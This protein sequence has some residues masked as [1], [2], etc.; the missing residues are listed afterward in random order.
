MESATQ[1]RVERLV[2]VMLR[3]ARNASQLA[4]VPLVRELC[5][6]LDVSSSVAMLRTLVAMSFSD[7][8]SEQ[9]LYRLILECDLDGTVSQEGAARELNVSRRHFYRLRSEAVAMIATQVERTLGH[10]VSGEASHPFEI[11]A[12]SMM[13]TK[14]GTAGD[15][16]S[17]LGDASAVG[18]RLL[19]LRARV[20]AGE[21]LTRDVAMTLPESGRPAA[22]ALVA[23]SQQVNGASYGAVQSLLRELHQLWDR[24]ERAFDETT[25]FELEY[26]NFLQQRAR[27][28]VYEMRSSA[29]NLDR[30]AGSRAAWQARALVANAEAACRAGESGE[31]R[32]LIATL[33]SQAT[34][35]RDVRRLGMANLFDATELLLEQQYRRAE[36]S[37][38]AAALA[39]EDYRPE[40]VLSQGALGRICLMTGATWEPAALLEETAGSSFDHITFRTIYARTLVARGELG[41]AQEYA[42]ESL[43]RATADEFTARAPFARV[44]L[45]ATF[46]RLGDVQ[47][48]QELYAEAIAEF[49]SVYDHVTAF[50]LFLVP[51][52]PQRAFGPFETIEP[53]VDVVLQRLEV[54]VPNLH[55][56]VDRAYCRRFVHSVLDAYSSGNSKLNREEFPSCP[57]H[58]GASIAHRIRA[59][60]EA[61]YLGAAVV[62]QA[63]ERPYFTS[64]V[65]TALSEALPN[66]PLTSPA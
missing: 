2:R 51:R 61:F 29:R 66:V 59:V 52:I 36:L 1:K 64:A 38:R 57:S 33:H 40:G 58:I 24:G 34:K 44:T 32:R 27:G 25:R 12:Q 6:A 10:P 18:I 62:L 14:P 39:L 56:A 21:L 37:A 65:R 15:I 11:L 17:L 4:Q 35:S 3:R 63:A 50:D 43:E 46:D 26:L 47:K 28:S 22:L 60:E 7:A 41:R 49:A 54:A 5:S 42:A 13:T 53:I 20:D 16:Y 45:A 23:Q 30:L 8:P 55:D 9:K 31:A 48:A 19:E